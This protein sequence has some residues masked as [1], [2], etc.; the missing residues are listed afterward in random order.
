MRIEMFSQYLSSGQKIIFDFPTTAEPEASISD[1]MLKRYITWYLADANA[2]AL[3]EKYCFISSLCQIKHFN[4]I[5]CS[6]H[7]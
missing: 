1:I 3:H 2:K 6:E 4:N 7:Q 5:K